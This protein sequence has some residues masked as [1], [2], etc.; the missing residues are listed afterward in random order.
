MKIGRINV[1]FRKTNCFKFHAP[2]SKIVYFN[3]G[4]MLHLVITTAP[5]RGSAEASKFNG[6]MFTW[7]TCMVLS[8]RILGQK[9]PI[10]R[11]FENSHFVITTTPKRR[12]SEVRNFVGQLSTWYR[13]TVLS[14]RTLAFKLPSW[15][16]IKS[17]FSDHHISVKNDVA[18]TQVNFG[19]SLWFVLDPSENPT[20]IKP[21][22]SERRL[23]ENSQKC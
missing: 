3:Q 6:W 1:L 7:Y 14:F 22:V 18:N 16:H 11:H 20:S 8:F 17:R 21:L 23:A 9:L 19:C 13:C 2:T 15:R 12:W 5:K 4:W 10:W